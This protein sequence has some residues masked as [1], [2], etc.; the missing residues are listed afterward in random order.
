MSS[1]PVKSK[2]TKVKIKVSKKS[3]KQKVKPFS[4]FNGQNNGNGEN[5][6]EINI[7]QMYSFKNILFSVVF[8]AVFIDGFN[9]RPSDVQVLSKITHS[10]LL[11][12]MSGGRKGK[13]YNK[14][15][16]ICC[17][18]LLSIVSHTNRT[19]HDQGWENGQ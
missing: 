8:L 17:C 11:L 5:I 18:L 14:I 10:R 1:V 19:C 13:N 12:K 4:T 6:L 16:L 2:S 7:N 15:I 3:E 9:M